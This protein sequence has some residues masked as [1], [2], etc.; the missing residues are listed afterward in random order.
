MADLWSIALLEAS[1]LLGEHA[2]KGVG[3][4]SH[5]DVKVILDQNGEDSASRLKNLSASAMAFST[6]HLRA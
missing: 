5:N 6:R 3:D 1:E 4:P 2:V